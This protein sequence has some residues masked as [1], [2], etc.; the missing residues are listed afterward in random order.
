MLQLSQRPLTGSDADRDL[1][2][3]RNQEL[4]HLERSAKL[5]FNVLVLGDR[6]IGV[7]S[8]VRQHQ[9]RLADDGRSVFYLSASRVDGLAELLTAIR[10][11]TT[12]PR[13]P[14]FVG[15]LIPQTFLVERDRDPLQDLRTLGAAVA[16]QTDDPHPIIL[17]DDMHEPSLVHELFG[18]HRDDVWELPFRWVVC[19]LSQSRSTYLE[20]PADA[21]FDTVLDVGELDLGSAADLLEARLST[22]GPDE[23]DSEQRIRADLEDILERGGGHPRILLAAA[24][25]ATLRTAAETAAADRLLTAAAALGT[26]EARAVHYLLTNGPTSA[27]DD[28]L[29]STLGITRARANQVLRNLE[30]A[31]LVATSTDKGGIGRPRKLYATSLSLEEAE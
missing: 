12:G 25:S 18:R 21:F 31:G 23:S 29:L 17:V 22:T 3:N 11:A 24:R 14:A 9:R 26:T 4:D 19:G 1:F 28:T 27:S 30:E 2:V 16:E 5:D 10:I 8:L 20:P 15:S 7:T 13:D 6:G